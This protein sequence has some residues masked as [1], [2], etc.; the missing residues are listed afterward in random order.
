MR[1]HKED[2]I[3]ILGNESGAFHAD[4]NLLTTPL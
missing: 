1:G 4:M 2:S 3:V